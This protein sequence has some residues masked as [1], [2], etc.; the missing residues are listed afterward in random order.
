[1]LISN[2]K[3][4]FDIPDNLIYLNCAYMSPSLKSVTEAGLK[5]VS[6][7][8]SPWKIEA[9]NFFDEA[10]IARGLFAKIIG[11]TSNDIAIIPSVSYGVGIATL[12]LPIKSGNSVVVMEDQFPSNYYGWFE[13][14]KNVGANL[15]VSKRGKDQSIT[16]NLINQIQSNTSV[17]AIPNCHWTDGAIIDIQSVSEK[18]HHVGSTIVLDLAQSAGVLPISISDIDPDFIIAPSYKWLLGPYSLTFIY[19]A[20]RWQEGIP[21]EHNW[22]NRS[23]SKD[24]SNLSHYQKDFQTGARRFDVGERSNFAIMPMAITAFKQILEWKIQNVN[25]TLAE[26]TKTIGE[27]AENIGLEVSPQEMRVDYLIGIRFPNGIPNSLIAKLKEKNVYV[28]IRGQSM[29]VSPY[30]YNSIDD[31]ERL[32]EILKIELNSNYNSSKKNNVC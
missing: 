19:I 16:D 26:L 25:E 13:K 3:D 7:K 23:H 4:L 27:Y 30:L 29:R 24:F 9:E 8:K 22:I 28:S 18:C 10:E 15:I 6:R 2:Q 17:V 21:L 11:A 1:M 32:F 14:T 5:G 12:N 20:P 31:I